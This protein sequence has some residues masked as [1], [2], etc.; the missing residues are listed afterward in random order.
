MNGDNFAPQ[1]G[2]LILNDGSIVDVSK[3]F[4]NVLKNMYQENQYINTYEKR[5]KMIHLG[6]Y[7]SLQSKITVAGS[8]KKTLAGLTGDKYLHI[9]P[10]IVKTTLSDIT[11]NVYEK[12]EYHNGT[13]V[14]PR[15]HNRCCSDLTHKWDDLV[16]DPVI[17]SYGT[18]IIYNDYIAGGTGIGGTS[19]GGQN[20]ETQEYV[21]PPNT[22]YCMD[23][24]NG[25]ANPNII[26]I[27]FSWYWSDKRDD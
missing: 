23:M 6:R 4:Y 25:N 12:I 2:K 22:K 7:F 17:D 19:Y 18:T 10:P 16:I 21:F 15:N 9:I 20:G 8:N 3:Y 26:Y 27:L 1:S 14:T 11:I 13:P 24:V 5:H